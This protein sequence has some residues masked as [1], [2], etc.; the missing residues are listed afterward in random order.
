M[1]APK[2]QRGLGKGL[3]ALFGDAEVTLRAKT[4]KNEE[5]NQ[6]KAEEAEAKVEDKEVSSGGI[7]Y[8]DINDIKPNSTQPRKIFD[9]GEAAGTGIFD[10]R[11]RS[12]TACRTE[13]GK[14]RL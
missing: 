7:A 1:A 6:V 4:D 8:I 12:H 3:D 14:Q 5:E 10:R 2:K 11:A 9:E 13:K